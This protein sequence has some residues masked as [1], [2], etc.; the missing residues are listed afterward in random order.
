MF[1]LVS[2][3]FLFL[4]FLDSFLGGRREKGGKGGDEIG[5]WGGDE[6]LGTYKSQKRCFPCAAGA[7]EE[8]CGLVVAV[9]LRAEEKDVE[10]D[11]EGQNDENGS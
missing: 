8:N 11:G 5:E 9:A 7:E 10:K 6:L 3:Y 2:F 1:P 4:I